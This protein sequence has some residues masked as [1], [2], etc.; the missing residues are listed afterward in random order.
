MSNTEHHHDD[1]IGH[2]VP[3]KFLVFICAILVYWNWPS[4]HVAVFE[5]TIDGKVIEFGLSGLFGNGSMLLYD[6]AEEVGGE[7]L[8]SAMLGESVTGGDIELKPITHEVSSWKSWLE[9]HPFT[10]S[11]A[12]DEGY[13]KRYRKGDPRTYF[14]NDTIYFP[15]SPM[16]EDSA[17]LKTPIIAV[18]TDS[19]CS[20]FSIQELID[21]SSEGEITVEVDGELVTFLVDTPPLVAVAQ[22]KD[23]ALLP[24]QRAL[25]FTW[26]ANHPDATLRSASLVENSTP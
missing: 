18:Q 3:I 19:G 2:T 12:P 9:R 14:L 25:W 17:N 21:I 6:K 7:Q 5:R 16:P 8:F 1:Q 24:S 11:L 23:G 22:D 15:V 4:G 26:F 10:V 20:V 13:K